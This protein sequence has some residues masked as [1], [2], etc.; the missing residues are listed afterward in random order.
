MKAI[1][2]SGASPINNVGATFLYRL[3]QKAWFGTRLYRCGQITVGKEAVSV[4]GVMKS[5][6]PEW[7][8]PD[9]QTSRTEFSIR[10]VTPCLHFPTACPSLALQAPKLP[11]VQLQHC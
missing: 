6:F 9:H 7:S 1:F 10:E 11:H 4:S 5:S 3:L 8:Q 2:L